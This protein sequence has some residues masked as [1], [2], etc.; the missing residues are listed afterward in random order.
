VHLPAA[1]LPAAVARRAL[2]APALVGVSTHVLAE[3][4]AAWDGGA[5]YVTFGPVFATR[6]KVGMGAPVG[7][8][9]LAE[10]VNAAPR[11]VF[12]LGGIDA[13][14]AGEVARLGARIACIGAVLGSGD[15]AAG[16]RA[17]LDAGA[18]R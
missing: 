9:A 17:F 1:G 11:P 16:A 7:L 14:R 8:G 15:A 3:V 2:G 12:A 13:A 5:D 6:S 4:A 10:A 18:I